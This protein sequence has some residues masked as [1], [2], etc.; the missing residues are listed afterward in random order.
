MQA[1]IRF[2]DRMTFLA[3]SHMQAA[4]HF[5]E[6]VGELERNH[7]DVKDEIRYCATASIFTVVAALEAYAN[8]LYF[9]PETSFP[10]LDSSVIRSEWEAL[11]WCGPIKKF[12]S[13]LSLWGRERLTESV[14]PSQDIALLVKL[15]NALV[16][17][18]PA[19]ESKKDKEHLAL[20]NAL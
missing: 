8:E 15:R 5:S 6:R 19:W 12:Q 2:S 1:I 18:S 14:R 7:T 9:Q 3:T 20:S 10:K 16:H 4:M 11:K 17:F 13:A